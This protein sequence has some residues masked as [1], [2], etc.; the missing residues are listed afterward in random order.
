M[1][2]YLESTK[3]QFINKVIQSVTRIDV[4]GIEITFNDTSKCL[5][6][7]QGDCCS[8]SIFYEIDYNQNIIGATIEDIIE[9]SYEDCKYSATNDSIEVAIN[10]IKKYNLENELNLDDCLSVWNVI[11]KTNRGDL[12]IRHI[13]S[14][15]GYYD[16]YTLY[17]LIQ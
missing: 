6:K 7:V 12:I 3:K 10:K 15:N 4:S 13:N 5:L 11:F 14:S 17:K 2:H 1:L 16:G 9:S 8:Y